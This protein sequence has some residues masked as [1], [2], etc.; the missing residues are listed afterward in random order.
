[1]KMTRAKTL[2][3]EERLTALEQRLT[4]LEQLHRKE[5][6]LY[7]SI[8]INDEEQLRFVYEELVKLR[9]YLKQ[10]QR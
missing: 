4:A 10:P 9:S 6:D 7:R 5:I 1:M 2:N 3:L 8:Q